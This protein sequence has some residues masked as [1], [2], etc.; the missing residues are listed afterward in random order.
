MNS[1]NTAS[2]PKSNK[3]GTAKEQKKEALKASDVIE[4]GVPPK[5]EWQVDPGSVNFE[6]PL[7]ECVYMLASMMQRPISVEALKAGLPHSDAHFT[8]DLAVRAAE[9]AGLTARTVRRAKI[10]DIQPVTL[11]CIILLKQGGACI[12]LNYTKSGKA[13]IAIPEGRGQK[14]I[15]VA[16]LQEQY[17]GYAIFA[18]TEYKFDSRASDIQLKKPKAW[19]WGTLLKFWPIYSHVMLASILI[20]LFAIASPLFVMNV[21]DRVVPNGA[22]ATLAVLAIGVTT[23]F[24]FEFIMKNLRTY[25]VD[26]AGKNADVII[27]SRLLEQLMAMKLSSKPPS[28]GAM[29]NNLREFESLR[30]FFTSGTLVALIDLPFIFLFIWI[31]S[32]VAAPQVAVIPLIVVPLVIL[33]GVFLQIPLRKVIEKTH[34]ESSQKHA[35]LVETIDGL[36]TIKTTAAEGRIQRSWERFVGLTADSAGKAK[37]LSG[38]STTFAQLSIQMTT[39]VVVIVGVFLIIEKEMTM[40][41]LVASSMLTG[42]ALAPLGT[43]AGMLTR[44]Q[45]SRVALKSLDNIMSSEVERSADKTYLHRPR[46]SGE[47]ELKKVTFNYPGQEV[48]ALD[49]VSLKIKPGERVGILG[50]IGSGKSTIARLSLGLYDPTEGSVLADGT[51]IRQ[52]DPADL[53]RNIGYVSQDNYLFFG[54]VK[55]NISFGAPHVDDQT[56]LR[57][58]SLAGVTDF[59][60]THP[61]GFDLQVG[62]RGMSL[63]GGQRQA[64]VIARSLLLDPPILLMDEPTSGMDNSSEAAFKQRLA[65]AVVGK[66]LVLVTHR[67]SLL[68]LVDRLV[69]VDSGRIVADGPKAEVLE[70]LK[71]GQIR[72]SAG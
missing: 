34:K 42:R 15:T 44:L 69:I 23:V 45:Q 6:D 67:S 65:K 58:A 51:D 47:I 10:E 68:T 38:I 11:P 64:V 54:S 16:E 25:L 36:E 28:T 48:K 46:L 39:V 14:E 30:D 59:L 37:L 7:L 18:R 40:G 29:A 21:Y 57:A 70:A 31:I 12:L 19:F 8:P 27:A 32:I 49:N 61:H 53:R 72:A 41:A 63:S 4:D 62:E 24:L 71:Q 56:I 43:I 17:T 35:L 55:E 60:K 22:S 2:K 3:K 26:V 66:T 20:N 13:S 52:I 50:R 9:R 1:D 33:V 5:E